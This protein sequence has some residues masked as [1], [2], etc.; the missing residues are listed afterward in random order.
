MKFA[1]DIQLSFANC[2]V[3]MFIRNCV[4]ID[5]AFGFEK[6]VAEIRDS[7]RMVE[8]IRMNLK[9]FAGRGRARRRGVA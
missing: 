1:F 6:F 2:I 4:W 8:K 9:I 3:A 7:L 5:H